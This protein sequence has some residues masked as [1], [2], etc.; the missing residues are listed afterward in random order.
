M[1]RTL[2]RG[3]V[4]AGPG[5]LALGGA[6]S[7]TGGTYINAGIL[8]A[9]NNTGSA[10]GMGTVSVNNGGTL[11]G[12]GTV[13]NVLVESGGTLAPETGPFAP[14][15][16]NTGS[17]FFFTGAIF[18]VLIDEAG[19]T[20]SQLN[21]KGT[22]ALNGVTLDIF[23]LP[24]GGAGPFTIIGNDGLDRVLGTFGTFTGA[25]GLFTT[26]YNVGTGDNDVTLS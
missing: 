4:F 14:A 10:T 19:G 6:N 21:V 2:A 24:G 20:G 3:N 23:L 9:T 26:S 12:D 22:V 7:Y 11:A 18:H 15:T 13:G 25:T 17:V 5:L 8:A 16:L 1:S